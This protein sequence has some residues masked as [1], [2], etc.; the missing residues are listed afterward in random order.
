MLGL[1]LLWL[2]VGVAPGVQGAAALELDHVYIHASPGAP[3]ARLFTDAGFLIRPDTTFHGGQGTA[4]LAVLFDNMYLELIWVTDSAELRAADEPL[5]QRLLSR[6]PGTS[7]FGLGLRSLDTLAPMP[8][9]TRPYHR[10][11]MAPGTSIQFASS[12]LT[13][14]MVFV[15]PPYMA[16]TAMTAGRPPLTTVLPHRTGSNAVTAV[17]LGGGGA[18]SRSEAFDYLLR[19][20]VAEWMSDEGEILLEVELDGG[21]TGRT[22]D[23]RPALPVVLR[24]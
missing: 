16:L 14:P 11:W 10:D 23:A 8:F 9:A 21:R 20:G 19:S 5:A 2:L 7:P 1:A 22:L 12:L 18:R 6:G 3:E 13:E 15:V 4:S 24:Y 17:R